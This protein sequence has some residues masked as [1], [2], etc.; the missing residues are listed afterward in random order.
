MT[1]TITP[2]EPKV[3]APTD[4]ELKDTEN[5]KQAYADELNGQGGQDGAPTWNDT[6]VNEDRANNY[7]DGSA[8]EESRG[9]GIKEDG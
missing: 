7:N 1:N 6:Q 5:D 2:S 8:E 4:K 9:V 3:E